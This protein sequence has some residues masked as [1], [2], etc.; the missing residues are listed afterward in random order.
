MGTYSMKSFLTVSK[1]IEGAYEDISLLLA[2]LIRDPGDIAAIQKLA[3]KQA[4]LEKL[5]SLH[6]ALSQMTSVSRPASKSYVA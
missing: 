3:I 5:E 1:E 4:Q 2:R 6:S